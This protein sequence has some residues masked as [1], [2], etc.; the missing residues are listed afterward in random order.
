MAEL[1]TY[2]FAVVGAANVDKA[3][4]SLERRFAQHNA[5]IDGMFGPKAGGAGNARTH[6]GAS[7]GAGAGAAAVREQTSALRKVEREQIASARRIERE[8]VTSERA[9]GREQQKQ[10]KYWSQARAKSRER[11]HSLNMQEASSRA[12]FVK[13]TVGKGFGRVAGIARSVGNAGLAMTG[14]GGAALAVSSVQQATKLDDMARRTAIQ[15]RNAGE[16]GMD[17]DA[18]RKKYTQTAIATGMSPEAV[19]AGVGKYVDYTGDLEG[20]LRHMNTWATLGQASGAAPE[21]LASATAAL[22]LADVTSQGDV[23]SSLSTL[24]AQGKKGSFKLQDQAQFLP[25]LLG[26]GKDFGAHGVEGVKSLGGLLQMTQDITHDPA[27]TA[28]G[29][30][31]MFSELTKH[32]AKMATGEAFGGH[33]VNVYEGGDAKKGGRNT[34]DVVGDVL[35][36]SRGDSAQ[37]EEVFGKRGMPAMQSMLNTFKETRLGA[38]KHGDTDTVATKK[39]HDA[40][41]KIWDNAS[42]V[43][44]DFTTVEKDAADTM[45]GFGVQLE[46]LE[47]Q[48]KDAA[49]SEL[50]PAIRELT[51]EILRLI[52]PVRNVT[53]VLVKLA[54]ALL[55]HPLEGLGAVLAASVAAEVLKASLGSVFT[56]ALERMSGVAAPDRTKVIGAGGGVLGAIGMGAAVGVTLATAIFTAGVVNFDNAE[57]NM[58]TGGSD[59]NKVREAGVGDIDMVR[60]KVKE[61][62]DKLFELENPSAGAAAANLI[63]YGTTKDETQLNT[64]KSYLSE[65][66]TKLSALDSLKDSAAALTKAGVSADVANVKLAALADR[67]GVKMPNTGNSPSPVKN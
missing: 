1:L 50:F 62:R 11:E 8:R 66:E 33:K 54:E 12:D 2:E 6:A 60:Q 49:A 37:I 39:G 27:E 61:H 63:S 17:P 18:L 47:T 38:L 26:R 52:G 58:K 5:K 19:A 65:M 51:P 36:A 64:E 14:I 16:Q 23:Q 29:V 21:D 25:S 31:D 42:D 13:S 41:L 40:A 32:A 46:I 45:K 57:V 9:V 55:D 24:Y 35:S 67:L 20:G 30:K 59:L 43:K 15:G 34:R 7:V 4:A 22:R 56:N 10:E 53:G 28:T 48:L 3:L 44:G